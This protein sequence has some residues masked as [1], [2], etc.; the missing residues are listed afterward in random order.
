M[1]YNNMVT[2]LGRNKGNTVNTALG[3]SDQNDT[4]HKGVLTVFIG[5]ISG[6]GK[7]FSMLEAAKEKISEGKKVVIGWL[8]T[9]GRKE[10]ESISEGI[11]SIE[12]VMVT[13]Q[14]IHFRKMDFD[15]LLCIKSDIVLI[16]DLAHVNSPSLRNAKRYQDVDELLKNGIDVYT[17]LNIQNLESMNHIVTD[18]IETVVHE[19]IPDSFLN[20]AQ[21]QLVDTDPE[22]L[23][24]RLHD[25]KIFTAGLTEEAVHHI[26][27]PSNINTLREITLRYA[28]KQVD[29][30]VNT[31]ES[32]PSARQSWRIGEKVLVYIDSY[33]DSVHLLHT[34]KNLADSLKGDLVV[35]FRPVPSYVLREKAKAAVEKANQTAEELGV[36]IITVSSD[37]IADALVQIIKR[38]NITQLVIGKYRNRYRWLSF[39]KEPLESYL[40]NNLT[41][42]RV[43]LIP[44]KKEM[45]EKALF[46]FKIINSIHPVPLITHIAIVVVLTIICKVFAEDLGL[47]NISTL[48]VIPLLLSSLW[49]YQNS[50]IVTVISFLL[51]DFFF[52]A[53][54]NTLFISDSRYLISLFIFLFIAF[55]SGYISILFQKKADLVEENHFQINSLF[56]LS[57]D[58]ALDNNI[59]SILKKIIFEIAEFTE[60]K[61]AILLPNDSGGLDLKCSNDILF[62]QDIAK[63]EIE[64]AVWSFKNKQMAGKGTR[65]FDTSPDF[66]FPIIAAGDIFG[67]MVLNRSWVSFTK[68]PNMKRYLEA[69]SHLTAIAIHRY[70]LTE[71]ANEN[72][73]IVE[74]QKLQKA[75]F[76]SISHDLNTPLT[77]IIGASGSLLD[78]GELYSKN[79][80]KELLLSIQQD[81]NDMNRLVRNLMDMA[82]L[83]N[84]V[85]QIKKEYA[86]IADVVDYCIRKNK[87]LN[88]RHIVRRIDDF[89]PSIR[90][91]TALI[92]QV[93]TNLLDNAIKYTPDGSS[94]LIQSY[95]KEGKLFFSM[96][97]EGIGIPS[98]DRDLVFTKFYRS[99][100]A[101]SKRGSGLGLSICKGIVE[102]HGGKIWITD[103]DGKGTR[104]HFF[105]PY[106][107]RAG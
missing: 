41:Y 64:V 87:H 18:I 33:A 52:I 16:D 85:I 58:I 99:N 101:K 19:T 38:V 105:I 74:S 91:D 30:E 4:H 48:F 46:R 26:Y 90:I 89:M 63:K 75:L 104:I 9:H 73:L 103:S 77:S 47:I 51:Y 21:I 60:A 40:I 107:R 45:G 97:D 96:E 62:E 70:Q 5:A 31:H 84:R 95:M 36:E 53:P 8:E 61:V 88:K 69:I 14:G 12:P 22:T 100:N 59:D 20:E 67:M 72:L 93:I 39:F 54:H 94:I 102:A 43:H 37:N 83:D 35:A 82:H 92:E 65:T 79:D 106:D 32:D 71:K 80:R 15:G 42:T 3:L 29:K 17:T 81:A 28:A 7:T 6:V 57:K 66:F 23:M 76:D 68:D 78:E 56:S 25:G 44:L 49:G 24:Q 11:Q 50:I 98:E 1:F 10:L 27:R 86:D 55:I 34:A 13:Y 2:Y